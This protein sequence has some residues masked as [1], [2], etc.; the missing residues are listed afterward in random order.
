MNQRK[1]MKKTSVLRIFLYFAIGIV[2]GIAAKV[3]GFS[4]GALLFAFGLY[5]T[6]IETLN[7]PIKG[8]KK[9]WLI[10]ICLGLGVGIG[11]VGFAGVVNALLLW[12][13]EAVTAV[14]VGLIA[15]T[16]PDVFK[17]AGERGRGKGSY[18]ALAVSFAALFTFFAVLKNV[19]GAEIK[20]PGALAL[21]SPAYPPRPFFCS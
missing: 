19:S 6:V 18:I 10:L 2:V 5:G 14:F 21:L 16:V 9:Y 15:G 4:G 12:K 3:P 20:N 17:S 7:S 1:L 11:Y 13:K 8:F